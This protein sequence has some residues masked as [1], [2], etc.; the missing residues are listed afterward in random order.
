MLTGSGI[1]GGPARSRVRANALVLPRCAARPARIARWRRGVLLALALGA[2]CERS[3]A[4][5][6]RPAVGSE[7]AAGE[8]ASPAS[9]PSGSRPADREPVPPSS[10]PGAASQPSGDQPAS[11]PAEAPSATEARRYSFRTTPTL[12]GDWGG[13]RSALEDAGFKFELTIQQQYQQNFRGGLETHNGHRLLGTYDMALEY[14]FDKLKLIPGGSFYIKVKGGYS[15][16]INP[17]KVGAIG[18]VNADAFADYAIFVRKWWYRQTFLNEKI[19]VRI[20]RIQ[21]NKD[22]FDVSLFANHE[23]KDF[24]NQFSIR[25]PTIPH[26]TAIGAFLRIKPAD[27]V[28]VQAATYDAQSVLRF[29]SGFDTAFHDEAWWIGIWEAGLLPKWS[30]P[31]GSMPGSYRVGLWYD[32]RVRSIFM[33][34]L[35]GR[36]EQRSRGDNVGLYLGVDQLVWKEN[37][38]A[39]DAQGLGL[40]SRFGTTR[41]DVQRVNNFWQIGLSY[42]GLIPTRDNDV[43]GF[44]VSQ[45]ILSDDFREHRDELADRETAYEWYYQIQVFPWMTVAPHLQ[46]ITNP[47]GG[48]DD[49][50]ALVGGIRVRIVL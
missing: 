31:K 22:L 15:D 28:Y 7:R 2:P 8:T 9:A 49:R 19:D 44:G 1:A 3:F 18:N 48:R 47:G 38:E 45:G 50:D 27:W 32:P 21:T 33:N 5:P 37:D 16:G 40:F 35:G 24:L 36:R 11:R 46:V 4:Q 20:G 43:L 10:E 12:T 39:R 30:S 26:A 29:R 23:D 34:T 6:A 17:D 25:N 42:R 13:V 14:D 41:A